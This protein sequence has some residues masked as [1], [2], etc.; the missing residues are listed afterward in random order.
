ML[1]GLGDIGQI[2]KLQR[3]FKSAQ[4]KIKKYETEGESTDGSVKAKVN[5][6]YA[7]VDLQ[8]D[9]SLIAG[10]DKRKIEK[11]IM[12]AINQAVEKNKDFAAQE[13]SGLTGG[14]N[15][16]GLSDFLK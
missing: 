5:G 7:V 9:Q 2:M 14:L 6:E 4:K 15:I 12:F 16:P 1:K 10:G 8:I 11:S 3:D 13:M